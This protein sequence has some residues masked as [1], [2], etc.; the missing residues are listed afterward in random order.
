[1]G[2]TAGMTL[3]EIL[4]TLGLLGVLLGIA[5]PDLGDWAEAARARVITRNL[6]TQ[7]ALARSTAAARQQWVSVCPTEDQLGCG[8]SWNEGSMVFSDRNGDRR[9]NQDDVVIRRNGPLPAGETLQWRAFQSRPYLQIEPSGFMRHQ[10]GN[11]TWCPASRDARFAR[12]L[13]VNATGRVRVSK[14]SDGDGIDEDS[15]GNPLSCL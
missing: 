14:D 9:V 6:A 4:L 3:L 13:V 2:R 7:I 11:F 10:S 12:Q 5:L 8:G 1:M 15:A